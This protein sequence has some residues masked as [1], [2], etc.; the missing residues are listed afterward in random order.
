MIITA[1]ILLVCFGAF[2]L[3][4]FFKF[5]FGSGMNS[6]HA[7]SWFVSIVISALSAGVIW[8]GLLQ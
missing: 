3:N 4:G 1:W 5:F 2:A 6:F 8:G 7:I